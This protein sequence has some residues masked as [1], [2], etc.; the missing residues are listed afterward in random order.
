ML[1]AS[2]PLRCAC[3]GRFTAAWLPVAAW[4]DG[5]ATVAVS[6]VQ[7]V[8]GSE[9]LLSARQVAA[10]LTRWRKRGQAAADLAFWRRHLEGFRS[11]RAFALV[12]E[13]LLGQEDYRA[14]LGLL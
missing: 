12:V 14:A 3:W 2:R 4:W 7:R 8:S 5:F 13:A 1:S 11:T 9:T 10:A 6:G